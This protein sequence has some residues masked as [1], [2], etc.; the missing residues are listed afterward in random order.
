MK[1]AIPYLSISFSKT[2]LVTGSQ[3]FGDEAIIYNAL[4]AFPNNTV[5]VHG[6]CARGADAIADRIARRMGMTVVREPAIWGPF[7]Q[8]NAGPKRNL[9]MIQKWKPTLGLAFRKIGALNKG[10]NN[11]I[12]LL[13]AHGIEV[14]LYE[15]H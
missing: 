10:T 9:L 14:L 15:G 4:K 3:F 12:S 8:K 6:A 11:T 13:R 7:N 5:I 2:V 1:A